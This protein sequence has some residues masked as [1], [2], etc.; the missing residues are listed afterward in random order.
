MDVSGGHSLRNMFQG[1]V[2]VQVNL[3]MRAVLAPEDAY[4]YCKS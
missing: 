3:M 4:T 2:T 1:V